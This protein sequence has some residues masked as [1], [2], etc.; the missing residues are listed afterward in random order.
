MEVKYT[1]RLLDKIWNDN[2]TNL[3]DASRLELENI[4]KENV[5]FSLFG[6]QIRQMNPI[7]LKSVKKSK[8]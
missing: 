1:L 8:I 2:L 6:K 3:G 4:I 5:R 7:A